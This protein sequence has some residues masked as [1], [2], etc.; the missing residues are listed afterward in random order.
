MSDRQAAR[1]A[2]D[3]LRHALGRNPNVVGIGVAKRD[4]GY[5]V[6]V[7]LTRA[8]STVPASV[9]SVAVEREVVGP[10]RAH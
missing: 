1:A 6:K 3:K 7:N 8:D 10:V 2:K 4:G 5:V 9:D